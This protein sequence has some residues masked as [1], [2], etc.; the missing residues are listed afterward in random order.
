[1]RFIVSLAGG[2]SSAAD[3]VASSTWER[4]LRDGLTAAG[5][6]IDATL[7]VRCLVGG[8]VHGRAAADRLRA[9]IQE[10]DE[11]VA[12]VAIGM[13]GVFAYE[14]LARERPV[15]ARLRA[16]VTIAVPFD[17]PEV[18]LRLATSHPGTQ[19]PSG[20]STWVDLRWSVG[21]RRGEAGTAEHDPTRSRRVRKVELPSTPGRVS[22]AGSPSHQE[23][24][25]ALGTVAVGIELRRIVEAR[26]VT[27]WPAPSDPSG[28]TVRDSSPLPFDIRP[29]VLGQGD[30]T[31][32]GAAPAAPPQSDEAVGAHGGS[33]EPPPQAQAPAAG[34]GPLEG[35]GGAEAPAATRTVERV[36]SADFPPIVAPG[37]EHYLLYAIGR[38]AIFGTSSGLEI[39]VPVATR[40]VTIKVVVYAPAF[41]V[42]NDAGEEQSWAELTVDV[43]EDGGATAKGQ[44]LLRANQVT[45]RTSTSIHVRFYHGTL[46][47][48]QL[49]L[50]TVVDPKYV[51]AGASVRL[52]LDG[53]R[54]PDYV[55]VITDAARKVRGKGPFDIRVSRD[56]RYIE[57]GLGQLEVNVASWE[58]AQSILKQFKQV[59]LIQDVDER[60]ERA[61]DVGLAL[62]DELPADFKRLYWDELHD[63]PD[64]SIAIYSQEPY[65][66]WEL[67][68]PRTEDRTRVAPFLG[69]SYSMARWKQARPF[70][71]PFVVDAFTVI[72]PDYV[73]PSLPDAKLEANDLVEKFGATLVPGTSKAVR[74]LLRSNKTRIVHFAGHGRYDPSAADASAIKLVDGSLV[75]NALQRAT[76]GLDAHPLVFLNACEVGQQ[77]WSLT[78]I[79]GWADAFC[80]AGFSA[81]V[82]PY[83]AVVD[84][85]SRKAANLFY[86]ELVRGSTV[87]EAIRAIRNRF[88]EDE[89]YRGHPSW[90]AYT[91]HCQPNVHIDLRPATRHPAPAPT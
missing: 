3:E 71:D 24:L 37:S 48:G 51:G 35:S 32:G 83:W 57:K 42:W 67:V 85:V 77:G 84:K 5:S 90:L 23:A 73:P 80:D 88:Y 10:T 44:L 20:L 15:V 43:T 26:G 76:L 16:L 82:G 22:M 34:G 25:R 69:I 74:T 17:E 63:Q 39:T 38:K 47:A 30:R 9:A 13:A 59:S 33:R 61:E 72:A 86:D 27:A 60:I 1:M 49:E 78:Q 50:A 55:F 31:N 41:T 62:W 21:D 45:R 75:P 70:P 12:L 4:A 2:P 29:S 11:Q 52:S 18:R 53:T 68:K 28:G 89:E 40:E 19:F 91:L 79:G 81:F 66:P 6:A 64:L 7:E 56:H 36:A 65:I 8:T 14:M 58:L 87:G 46:P 54:E